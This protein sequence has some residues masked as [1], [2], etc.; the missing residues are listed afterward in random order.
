MDKTKSL[1]TTALD[2]GDISMQ[3]HSSLSIPDIAAQINQGMGVN[4]GDGYTK[5]SKIKLVVVLVDDSW[6]IANRGNADYV[7]RGVNSVISALKESRNSHEIMLSIRFFNR[8]P[9]PFSF[10]DD[11]ELLDEHSYDPSGGTPL[12]DQY[13]ATL[14]QMMLKRQESLAE[15]FQCFTAVMCLTD[16]N[17]EHSQEFR[18]P[19]LVSHITEDYLSSEDN[20]LTMAA[21]PDGRTN[22]KD[23]FSNMG[24]PDTSMKVIDDAFFGSNDLEKE[25]RRMFN[26]FSESV[27]SVGNAGG[28]M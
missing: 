19:N 17:D 11:I 5:S 27:A 12:Y 20:I 23:I 6:S 22:F 24:V 8:P 1:L 2:M 28:F 25:I 9:I 13:A 10:L 18:V 21:V 7:R 14:G 26:E 4:L 16:G 3:T 15:G